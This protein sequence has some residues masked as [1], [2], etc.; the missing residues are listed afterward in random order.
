MTHGRPILRLL[1]P[2]CFWLLAGV[3]LLI[4]AIYVAEQF[5]SLMEFIVTNGGTAWDTLILAALQTPEVID[6]ALPIAILI[7]MYFAILNARDSNE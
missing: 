3:I 4:E 6:F 5:S 2:R 7:A 1:A